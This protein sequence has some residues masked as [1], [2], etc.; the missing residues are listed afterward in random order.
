MDKAVQAELDKLR[1]IIVQTLPVER[2]I[3]FGSYAYGVP[4][5]DSD[6]DLYVVLQ[7]GVEMRE[8]DAMIVIGQALCNQKTMP[9]DIIVGKSAT[10]A[11]RK[12]LPTIERTIATKGM[13][14]YG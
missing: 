7:E 3:L 14:L 12:N 4:H 11:K 10:F 13:V 8:I 1:D 9:T 5:K 2:I 6:L